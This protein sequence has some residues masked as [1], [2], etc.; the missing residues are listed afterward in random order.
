MLIATFCLGDT[1]AT[2]VKT[3]SPLADQHGE[4]ATSYKLTVSDTASDRLP[5]TKV[6]TA[7]QDAMMA[8]A[9]FIASDEL[10]GFPNVAKALAD[11]RDSPM[12]KFMP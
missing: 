10:P 6:Y 12:H 4:F 3:T 7:E 9:A 8:F 2:V 5:F 11:L 1:L